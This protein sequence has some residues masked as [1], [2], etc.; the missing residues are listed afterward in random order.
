[1]GKISNSTFKP[2]RK[3]FRIKEVQLYICRCDV[4]TEADAAPDHN[5]T[6]KIPALKNFACI[7]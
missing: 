2:K 1:M 6:L 7:N 5:R 4:K 3:T